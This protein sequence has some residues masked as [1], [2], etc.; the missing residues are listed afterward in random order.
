MQA[1]KRYLLVLLSCA[2]LAYCYF[3]GYR[4]K[5]EG[6]IPFEIDSLPSYLDTWSHH[7]Y[8]KDREPSPHI[9]RTGG[10]YGIRKTSNNL[11]NQKCRME[12][13]FDFARCSKDFKVYVYPLADE[14]TG[15]VPLSPSPAYQKV[16]DVITE[17]RYYTPDPSQACLF[18]L[19]IDTLDRDNLSADYVRNV[20]SRLQRLKSW[21]GGR[22]HVI[23]N[24][25]SGTWPEYSEDDLGFDTGEAILAKASMST[26]SFRPGFDISIPL[27][28]KNHPEK[29]GESGFVTTNNFP[30]NKKYL[31]AFKG[32]RY[33]H[34]IG[35]ETR[36]SLYHLHNERDIVLVTTCR[37]GKSWKELK[38]ER[39]DE[40]NTEYDRSVK[41]I[42]HFILLYICIK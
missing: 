23:F 35:S 10:S 19:A 18:V 27:F 30:A 39:C 29:G 13:C 31:L 17:S 28:H 15:E 36:N 37:H 21:N 1:K 12:T 38:D 7:I 41:S 24:L 32:K 14:S 8:D 2:F 6:Y 5:S 25:Y 16:L 9:R 11:V 40:D 4:L 26:T 22:N 42:F 34:G 20:P 3:G 33:V